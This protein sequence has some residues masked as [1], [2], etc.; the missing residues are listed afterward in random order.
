MTDETPSSLTF[1]QSELEDFIV[2]GAG[3]ETSLFGFTTLGLTDGGGGGSSFE[4]SALNPG[5]KKSNIKKFRNYKTEKF[6]KRDNLNK[7][8]GT[9]R[10]HISK[11]AASPIPE[12]SLP[13]KFVGSFDNPIWGSV[14]FGDDL[15]I[16]FFVEDGKVIVRGEL[17]GFL[18]F[19]PVFFEAEVQIQGG[20]D[21][22]IEE[23]DCSLV[24]RELAYNF[25]SISANKIQNLIN[26]TAGSPGNTS[27]D[28]GCSNSPGISKCPSPAGA[29]LGDPVALNNL[30]MICS[31]IDLQIAGRGIDYRFERYYKSRVNFN[32]PIGQNWD[33]NYNMRLIQNP[34]IA[35][36]VILY[37]RM[38]GD[39][40][41]VLSDGSILSPETHFNKIVKDDAGFFFLREPNGTIYKFFPFDDPQK[42]AGKL[43]SITTRCGNALTMTYN[44]K[45]LLDT[46][47]DS[48]SRPI[49]HEYDEN[50]RLVKITDFISREVVYSYNNLGQLISVRSPVVENTSNGNDFPDGKLYKYVYSSGF[51]NEALNHN[52]LEIIEPNETATNNEA[53][54]TNFYD[55]DDRL[56][57]QD[58]SGTN[59]SGVEAG[60]TVFFSREEINI[61]E[62]PD[63]LDLPREV[64][65]VTDRRGNVTILSYNINKNLIKKEVKTRGLREN[66]PVSFITTMKYNEAGLQ[67]EVIAPLQN[68]VVTEYD[69]NNNNVFQRGNPIRATVFPDAVRGADQDFL[70]VE[71]EYEP[72]FNQLISYTEQ[73]E[74][75][76]NFE[77]QN[78]GPITEGRYT[79][80]YIP[81]YFE[82][83]LDT[84]GCSCGFTL[85]ELIEKYN[86][87]ISSVENKLEQGDLNEDSTFSICGNM[88]LV[89]A[90]LV[91]LRNAS[92]QAAVEGSTVQKIETR[93]S[94][95]RYGQILKAETAEGEVTEYFYYPENDPDG[96]GLNV[97]DGQNHLGEEFDPQAGYLKQVIVD[98]VHTT[99]YR[100]NAAPTKLSSTFGYDRVGNT[101]FVVNPR[102]IRSE[103]TYNSLNQI[104]ETKSAANVSQAAED[105]LT[106]FAYKTRL[107]YDNNN[108]VVRSEVEYRDGNNPD[109][110]DFIESTVEYDI[111]NNPIKVTQRVDNNKILTTEMRYDEN[112]NLIEVKSPLAVSGADANNITRT[113][114]DERD[115]VIATISSPGAAIESKSTTEIDANGNVLQVAD[116]ED[117]DGDG[118]R[119]K[120][121]FKYD[122]FD[123]LVETTTSTGEVVQQKYDP[124]S[125]VIES[126][127]FGTVSGLSRT[128]NST[129]GNTLLSR[130]HAFY[131]E[132]SRVFKQEAELFVSTGIT[133]VR[134]VVLNDDDLSPGDG[135]VTS[136]VEY[137]RNSRTT[138]T[139][140][141][142]PNGEEI[143]SVEYDG[144]SR[145][146]RAVDA[147]N[148]EVS[149]VYDNNS[150]VISIT[151]IE[152]NSSGRIDEESFT[153]TTVYD[154]LDRPILATDNIG[155]TSY[156]FYDS[157]NL[158][159]R[160]A[161]A[162]GPENSGTN[163]LGNISE[164]IHDGLGRVIQTTQEITVDGDGG[165]PLDLSNPSNNDGKITETNIW[166]DNS[167]L[168]S[169]QDDNGNTT[170]YEYDSLNRL[171]R[172]IFADGKFTQTKYAKDHNVL[173]YIDNNGSVCT[174]IYDG[175]NRIIQKNIARSTTNNIAGTT[176]QTFEYDGLSR[177]IKAI[178]NNDPNNAEDDSIVERRYDSLSRMLEEK[179]NGHVVSMNWREEGDLAE[180]IYPNNRKITYS[181]DKI[182]RVKNIS[183]ANDTT[184]IAAYDYI[185]SRVI[186][187][188]YKNGTKL[189]MLNDSG[190]ENVGYDNLP[191]LTQLRHIGANNELIQ[192]Y[193]YN[194]NRVNFKTQKQ[195][196]RFANLSEKYQL[197]SL[198]RVVDFKRGEITNNDITTST[199]SQSWQLDG[200]GNW[201]NTTIDGEVQTQTINEMNE[202]GL[203]AG[204]LQVFDDNGNLTDDSEKLFTYD[205]LN[206]ITQIT[207]KADNELIAT[208]KYDFA[209]RR[210]Q[211]EF[212]RTTE[213]E[214]SGGGQQYT[215]D[216][217][218]VALY[219]YNE[220]SGKVL[221]SS[222]NNN[223]ARAPRF[224]RKRSVDGL[225]GTKAVKL[226]GAP[227]HV[228]PSTSL[229]TIKDKLTLET[230]VY[231]DEN[232]WRFCKTGSLIHRLG[233]YRLSVDRKTKKACFSLVTKQ[234]QKKNKHRRYR[235]RGHNKHRGFKKAFG[236]ICSDNALPL[237]EW[238]H[239]AAVYDGEN[240]T[241]YINCEKQSQEKQIT[242]NVH[243]C[244]TPLFLGGL[245]FFG[246][247]EETRISKVARSEF[248]CDPNSGGEP[249]TELTQIRRKF[250]YSDWRVIE[251]HEQRAEVGQ[252]FGQEVVSRQFVDG[253]GIDEHLQ[254]LV[255]NEDGTAVED[256]RY[257]H[258]NH[259][260]DTVALS[261]ENGDVLHLFE[262]TS[263]GKIFEINENSELEEFS[264]F[265]LLVYGFHG[266]RVDEETNGLMY[267][268]NRYYSSEFGRFLQRDSL[269]YVDSMGLY[270][271]FGG[272]PYSYSDAFGKN[273]EIIKLFGK[274]FLKKW[275]LEKAQEKAK[276]LLENKINILIES[277]SLKESI[278]NVIKKEERKL[279]SEEK[280][281]S[282][283]KVMDY[284]AERTPAGSA[285]KIYKT[286]KKAQRYINLYSK[287]SGLTDSL[288]GF[289]DNAKAVVDF[290]GDPTTA[291]VI[292]D[293]MM[294]A[295]LDTFK[296]AG[297]N[298][299]CGAASEFVNLFPNKN[300]VP[301]KNRKFFKNK[302][303]IIFQNIAKMGYSFKPR[304]TDQG[305]HVAA[306][307]KHRSGKKII[308][309]FTAPLHGGRYVYSDEKSYLKFLDYKRSRRK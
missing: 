211:K 212:T 86:I 148:N 127:I 199:Q 149:S 274:D 50:N 129:T 153:S 66:D 275:G 14:F 40:Y 300:S 166:D 30:E 109:L 185:G 151:S 38:R 306:E 25:L 142:S 288:T 101:I 98:N 277:T 286:R 231:I 292:I 10:F 26:S 121:L 135:R 75:T 256:E 186:E 60:G 165:S 15:D 230:F 305:G 183:D 246:Q 62:A 181:Y 215:A 51:D 143:S 164:I 173:E 108:N 263:Y 281:S 201:A 294:Q 204:N 150:N 160:T 187:R 147:E 93:V 255:F 178:D 289:Y 57:K 132:L 95:S 236:N 194:Y 214:G 209:N 170:T 9:S 188:V 44:D 226:K 238:V 197:D 84:V 205:A 239:I 193:K 115:L 69:E 282:F 29:Q 85:R 146:I 19:A 224:K 233:G 191:R 268:R 161:D 168:T 72:V 39:I 218:T 258:E 295:K 80:E 241:L 53:S 158:T 77:P 152:R 182:D 116:A 87:D 33:H 13:L 82:G 297:N 243:P 2:F 6:A 198:Y 271:A 272:N 7:S 278:F 61:E 207:N 138:F 203:I 210:I 262:Y 92:P 43:A 291:K 18:P 221:D 174:Y 16:T 290:F 273:K 21:A 269:G 31:N 257:F 252:A 175:S 12:E 122:G 119:E 220:T 24:N 293:A 70:K 308:V 267:F 133:T 5:I 250:L 213:T 296:K 287:L 159:I 124:A 192:G 45:G 63:D 28:S 145:V 73:R 41:T 106:A 56:F 42:R 59:I 240:M 176:Q 37:H 137:D 125:N 280:R 47:F 88:I 154:A 110:P 54:V 89:K 130:T 264:D 156:I 242:G 177:L 270:E 179:Q 235:R 303:N 232:K 4:S 222:G 112:E 229:N 22:T 94:Y 227:I 254:M 217:D 134:P 118:E 107:F 68:R 162:Q 78:G 55:A 167:R 81:D 100:G 36:E 180:C 48:L 71:M 141:A 32:G 20:S 128:A 304:Y 52:L 97:L 196:L 237:N 261:D 104:V 171:I 283:M 307:I 155:Q 202:Y 245:G 298:R 91:N 34:G 113:L 17:F 285:L 228:K 67:T 251:E 140:S 99:R 208:Y 1:E 195:N 139:I 144:A 83:N 90:P 172:T 302:E 3:K 123:R 46:V 244:S 163:D 49:K 248:N 190:N 157:R 259:R 74:L 117:T 247:L 27:C 79:S 309:D 219:H 184:P 114:Y 299:E 200:V 120:T 266:R 216:A 76:E 96:D 64:V 65:T 58:W 301:P 223:H 126:S 131:D 169:V 189:T 253:L 23:N 279:R 102:G 206:R 103:F 265:D 11:S 260:G 111:L 276:Q 225:F 234:Q 105:N 249:E 284:L 136:F 35:T 8:Q